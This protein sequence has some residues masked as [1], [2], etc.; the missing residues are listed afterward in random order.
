MMFLYKN[1]QN[2]FLATFVSMIAGL[3]HLA[4]ILVVILG[5]TIASNI[6]QTTLYIVGGICFCISGFGVGRLA[7]YISTIKEESANIENAKL[8]D[9]ITP[10]QESTPNK[11]QEQDIEI[12][13]TEN[14]A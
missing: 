3:L 7:K 13:N 5:I 9:N 1:Y 8:S 2:S 10:I 4:A 14:I 12:E 6:S 11:L